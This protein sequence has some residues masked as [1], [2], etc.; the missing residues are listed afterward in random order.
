MQKQTSLQYAAQIQDYYREIEK[1]ERN[2]GRTEGNLRF[3]FQQ[4]LGQTASE[5]G[6]LVMAEV[7]EAA[8]EPRQGREGR[9]AGSNRPRVRYDGMVLR[10]GS[11]VAHGYWEAKD[12]G[13]SLLREVIKKQEAGYKFSNILFEDTREFML[14]Q[15]GKKVL[16]GSLQSEEQLSSG[17]LRFYAY[18]NEHQ[19][20][21]ERALDAFAQRIPGLA[22]EFA[23]RAGETGPK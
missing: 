14:Y 8:Q 11:P 4:L 13:D 5:H 22:G 3:A 9:K 19:Q 15:N 21:F 18:Q 6:M 7:T 16:A 10:E 12:Q 20:N 17:L 23:Q 1:L 2:S